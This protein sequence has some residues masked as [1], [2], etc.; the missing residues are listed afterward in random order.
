MENKLISITH[1]QLSGGNYETPF[2]LG[3]TI[4]WIVAQ[5]SFEALGIRL[6]YYYDKHYDS[7]DF[8]C[9]M[10]KIAGVVR[11]IK[12][13]YYRNELRKERNRR[14]HKI[15]ERIYVS[16]VDM[17]KATGNE[18]DRDALKC[19]NYV[20][21]LGDC[22]VQPITFEQVQATWD[23]TMSHFYKIA[24]EVATRAH[25]GQKDMAAQNMCRR[26]FQS[27]ISDKNCLCSRITYEMNGRPGRCSAVHTS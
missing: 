2:K 24:L 11:G 5:S 9:P 6:D 13:L 18:P 8:D 12:A 23:N 22:T 10:F 20:V 14:N 7:N 1:H 25:E 17:G 15:L 16:V 26:T 21:I 27:A 3:D 4:E 19:D